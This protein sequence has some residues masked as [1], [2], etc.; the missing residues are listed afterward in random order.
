VI[1]LVDLAAQQ[2]AIKDEIAAAIARVLESSSFVLGDEVAAFETEFAAFCEARY[3]VAVNSGT[4]ALHLALLAAGV[5]AGDEVITAPNTF[6]ATCEAISYTGA[7]PVFVDVRPDTYTIDVARLEAAIT[8]R[9]RAIIPVHLY[10]QPADLDPIVEI[11]QQH[12]L[13]IVED[14]CQAHGARYKGRRVGT[15]GVAGCFSFYPAK[16]L[17]AYGDCGALVTNDEAVALMARRLRDHGQST[18]YYHDVVGY[19]YRMDALQAAILRVKLRHLEEWTAAR[20]RHAARYT[21]LLAGPDVVTPVE[22]PWAEAVYHLYVV[23]VQEREALREHLTRAGIGTGIHYPVP[24]HLQRAYASLGY[25]TGDFPHTEQCAAAILSLPMYPELTEEQIARVASEVASPLREDR[26]VRASLG[27]PVA[28]ASPTIT[29]CMT[30]YNEEAVIAATI[31]ECLDVL[32]EVPGE[33]SILVMNDGSTDSTGRILEALAASDRRVRVLTNAT[34]RG[35]AVSVRRLFGAAPG[36]VIF[37]I[38]GDGEWRARELHGLLRK[39]REGFD[40][41]VG[42]RRRKNYGPYRQVVSWIFNR[43]IR[44]VFGQDL[45]DAGSITLA[46]SR[47]WKRIAPRTDSAFFSAEVL[48]LAALDGARIGFAPVDHVWRSTG[49]SNFNSPLRALEAFIDL[50]A[51]RLSRRSRRK[52]H[53]GH[54]EGSPLPATETVEGLPTA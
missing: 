1:P 44:V 27:A 16:N 12:R 46:Y 47:Q 6:I 34:N 30:V 51:F 25:R 26:R 41:V 35:F 20:R 48:L 38:A 3:A 36:E 13:A 33:H 28:S 23:R 9:T 24:C 14:A 22:A 17:G 52:T 40:V 54:M 7:R 42:I 8:P 32:D 4:S 5:G 31:R 29:I 45:R 15:S 50:C 43:L 49:K 10:G 11:A 39:L 21:A 19:N 18:R 53:R 37:H 2:R